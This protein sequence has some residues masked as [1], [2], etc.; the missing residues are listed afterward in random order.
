MSWNDSY[1]EGETIS[2]QSFALTVK[3]K[4]KLNNQHWKLSTV[5]D[6]SHGE[7]RNEFTQ[8]LYDLQ[9]R[10]EENRMLIG[11]F[12]Y[13]R[14][15][16][17]CNRDG[18][19]YS[20]M[21]VFNS[22]ISHLGLVEISVKGRRFTWSNKQETPLLEQLDWCFTSLAWTASYQNTF[23]IPLA[24]PISDHIPCCVQ[25]GTKISKA[26]VFRFENFWMQ[27]PGFM[28][29]VQESWSSSTQSNNSTSKI[30]AKFK[31]LRRTL[32]H[33]SKG[34]N[35]ISNLISRCNDVINT[36]DKIVEQRALFI[37]PSSHGLT[38]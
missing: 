32:K 27:H 34:I 12:N 25:I 24:K 10:A 23:L 36:L 2:I 31:N 33:W 6:P 20:D 37:L 11:D 16:E 17:D 28:E 30:V 35:K 7:S 38:G 29:L 8:W 19:N 5:Y 3:F 13:Y 9:I 18:A 21:E 26:N 22:T 4:S 15:P 1:L 14:S